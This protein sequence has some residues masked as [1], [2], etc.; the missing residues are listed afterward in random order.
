[1]S[2]ASQ[3]AGLILFLENSGFTPVPF[4]VWCS[5]REFAWDKSKI[6]DE[7]TTLPVPPDFGTQLRI[8]Q[9]I[10]IVQ[11]AYIKLSGY[12]SAKRNHTYATR[13]GGVLVA[14]TPGIGAFSFSLAF[15]TCM[16]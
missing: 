11:P 4:G 10:L 16:V 1:M 9:N 2:A 7:R 13:V 12:I 8:R 5:L 6:L 14:G 15:W 3:D